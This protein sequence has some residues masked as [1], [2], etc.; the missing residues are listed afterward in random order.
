MEENQKIYLS[1]Y[2]LVF[3][4]LHRTGQNDQEAK[5][6]LYSS[7]AGFITVLLWEVDTLFRPILLVSR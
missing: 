6:E 2:D 7:D 3:F 5:V 4:S 1:G